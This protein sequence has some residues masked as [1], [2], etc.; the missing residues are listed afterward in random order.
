M[1]QSVVSSLRH[2]PPDYV[3]LTDIADL[4]GMSRQNLRKLMVSHLDFPTPVH[5][6]THSQVWHLETVL[7]WLQARATYQI[8]PQLIEVPFE[9]AVVR[10]S[11][12][13]PAR[14]SRIAGTVTVLG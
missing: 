8:E 9:S 10:N 4:V 11:R 7:Q 5:T 14:V 3:G 2:L 6:A 12:I 13:R 1:T